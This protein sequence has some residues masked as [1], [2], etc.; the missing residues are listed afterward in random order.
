MAMIKGIVRKLPAVFFA[1]LAFF[2]AGCS[3]SDD[4]DKKTAD[5]TTNLRR[6][7]IMYVSAQNSLGYNKFNVSDSS[8]I[9]AGAPFMNSRDQFLM[10][11]DDANNPRVYR[12]Y[13]DCKAPQL[14]RVYSA[15]ADS[16]DP[17]TL[18]ELLTWV[19]SKYP[20]ESYGLVM[21]SHADGWMP[22]WSKDYSS[23][24]TKS[25]SVD[26]GADGNMQTDQNA[27]GFY[28]ATMDIDDMATAIAESGLHFNY[29]FFD[30]CLMQCI[31][32]DYSLRNVT[33]Y[34]VASPISTPAIGA[35][36]TTMIRNAFYTDDPS[37]IAAA[38]Y[39]YITTLPANNEYSDFGMVISC[40]KTSA[41][42][43][44]AAVTKKYI[45]AIAAYTLDSL[46]DTI[47]NYSDMT[48]VTKYNP[49]LEAYFWRP[50]FYDLSDAM[51]A[52]L[53]SSD[54]EVWR[55]ALDSCVVYKA[56]TSTFYVDEGIRFSVNKSFYSG[57]SAF[58]PQRIYSINAARCIFGDLN[59]CFRR[60][61]WYEDAGWKDAGW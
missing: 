31:E 23:V 52:M 36:Y 54:Y 28:G 8:E 5:D 33:D 43:T 56:A 40:V 38:Y 10:Y 59:K 22:S 27:N 21:W 30:A 12:I 58:V 15:D 32:T 49:Y 20:S 47:Y 4:G 48:N 1:V 42:D 61:E 17:G 9:M 11:V 24:Q 25:F 44:L 29:I 35:N 37:D 19:G 57:V 16:S 60:L 6:T 53:S 7:V 41:L 18:K 14:V 34:V 50:H 55:A 13:K 2:V 3:S 51:H 45:S 46:G 26:V 39:N